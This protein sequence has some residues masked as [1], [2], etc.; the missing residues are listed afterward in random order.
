MG[1]NIENQ[2]KNSRIHESEADH[3]GIKYLQQAGFNPHAMSDFF[4]R[5]EK[6]KQLYGQDIPE[7][8][9]THP[10]THTRLAKAKDRA[11]QLKSSHASLNYKT[12]KLIQLRLLSQQGIEKSQYQQEKL[13]TE[14]QCY[15]NNSTG[16]QDLNCLNNAIIK[17]PK[18]RLYKILKAQILV[19]EEPEK[20]Y[21][22]Y[23]YLSELYPSDFSIPYLFAVAYEQNNQTEKAITLL[24]TVTPQF[25]YQDKLYTKLAQLY[26][27][28]QE[29][30]RS[31]YYEA[32][33][34]FNIGNI[35]K[36]KHLIREAKK[37]EADKRSLFFNN[38]T[39]F[40][41]DV[42]EIKVD[43]KPI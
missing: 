24:K 2:L 35:K 3:I 41:K 22:E 28:K 39:T 27:S 8:L 42:L 30:S 18:E 19:Q 1:L 9:L 12:L 37:L 26:A 29:M 40:E 43:K 25:F 14:E 13:T 38:L 6:E 7:I 34:S 36:S 15:L 17:F 23:K 4:A 32:L 5:L 10:V 31:Y 16:K 21:K 33:A 20:S 11:N